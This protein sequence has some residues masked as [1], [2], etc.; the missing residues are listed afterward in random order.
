MTTTAT[1]K[2]KKTKST[3]TGSKSKAASSKK[4]TR[5]TKQSAT[6]KSAPKAGSKSKSAGKSTTKTTASKT[7]AKATKA[8]KGSTTARGKA[9]TTTTRVKK[10]A[11]ATSAAAPKPIEAPQA[12]ATAKPEKLTPAERKRQEQ[13]RIDQIWKTFKRTGDENLRNILVE[14]HYPL[15]RYI[16][17]RLLQTLPKSIDVDDLISAGTFGLLDAI[18]GFDLKRG[19]KFK[20]YCSTRIRGSILDELRSQDWVPRLVRLKAHKLDKAVSRLEALH[21]REVNDYELAKDLEITMDE[22][23]NLKV[24]ASPKTMFSLSEKLDESD[25]DRDMEKV[26]IIED[27][28]GCDP[29]QSLHQQDVLD[30]ITSNLTKKERLIVI[31]YYYEGLTMREIGDIMSLT[32]SRVCQIH[33]NVMGRLKTQLDAIAQ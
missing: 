29:L 12:K 19:I 32:E 25:D 16:A 14:Y 13:E 26:E 21:G 5:T 24:E 4:A 7:T 28:K 10:T 3:S 18:R 8:A 20:T 30:L 6:T 33:S 27:K 31:M 9:A 11:A 23:A 15:V 22:L 17:E 1:R 2:Q